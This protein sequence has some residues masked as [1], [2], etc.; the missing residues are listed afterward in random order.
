[1]TW[2]DTHCHLDSEHNP[3]GPNAAL[4]R[5]ELL[6]MSGILLVAVLLWSVPLRLRR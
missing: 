6:V 5:A 3:A 4:E 2:F 1:M